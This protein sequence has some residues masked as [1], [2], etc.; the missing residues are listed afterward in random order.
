MGSGQRIPPR[1]KPNNHKNTGQEGSRLTTQQD[2]IYWTDNLPSAIG[3]RTILTITDKPTKTTHIPTKAKYDKDDISRHL[4]KKN[5]ETLNY[6]TTTSRYVTD[7]DTTLETNVRVE[8]GMILTELGGWVLIDKHENENGRNSMMIME[9]ETFNG[10]F[11]EGE[12]RTG[13]RYTERINR[14]K[15]TTDD[16]MQQEVDTALNAGINAFATTLHQDEKETWYHPRTE[17]EED[18][19]IQQERTLRIKD[20]YVVMWVDRAFDMGINFGDIFRRINKINPDF[21]TNYYRGAWRDRE[22]YYETHI[23]GKTPITKKRRRRQT[24]S[25]QIRTESRTPRRQHSGHVQAQ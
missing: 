22:Q 6:I 11:L 4:Q 25:D 5:R 23:E 12:Y 2:K 15:D 14:L 19:L 1:K 13:H 8:R 3:A 7:I 9:H 24:K 18:Q 10:N 20:P 21:W 17:Y 16:R